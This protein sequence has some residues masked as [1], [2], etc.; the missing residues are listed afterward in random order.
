MSQ[1]GR[2]SPRSSIRRR[3]LASTGSHCI[4]GTAGSSERHLHKR[5]PSRW[6]REQFGQRI[7]SLRTAI[8]AL[9]Q[10]TLWQAMQCAA[11]RSCPRHSAH[12]EV[13]SANALNRP[14]AACAR[15]CKT[16]EARCRAG[17]RTRRAKGLAVHQHRNLAVRQHFLGF[18][19]HQQSLRTAS[20]VR[21]H[22]DQLASLAFCGAIQM[23]LILALNSLAS[24]T[25][26]NSVA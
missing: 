7:G 24:W 14:I 4:D 17:C 15:V 10:T 18:T 5:A 8:D 9:V 19:A 12:A 6:R 25:P 11:Y 20:A 13:A 23:P 21:S 3:S 26:R 2:L 22:H 1:L 16:H